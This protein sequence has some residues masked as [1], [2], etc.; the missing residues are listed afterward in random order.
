MTDDATGPGYQVFSAYP[1]PDQAHLPIS[2]GGT[3]PGGPTPAP[4]NPGYP[5]PGHIMT[6]RAPGP[7]TETWE[8]WG[9]DAMEQKW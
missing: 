9:L 1:H 5:L 7:G 6:D 4:P 3:P 8:W 2:S